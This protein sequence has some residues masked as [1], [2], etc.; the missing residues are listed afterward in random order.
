MSDQATYTEHIY[1]EYSYKDVTPIRQREEIV[2]CMDCKYSGS[3]ETR[4]GAIDCCWCLG[5]GVD[6][7]GFCAWGKKGGEQNEC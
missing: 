5:R 1:L 3:S 4:P 2:R 6:P 7:Y